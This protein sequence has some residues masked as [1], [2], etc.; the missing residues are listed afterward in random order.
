MHDTIAPI[1]RTMA[2]RPRSPRD[3]NGRDASPPNSV[4]CSVRSWCWRPCWRSARGLFSDVV[5]P[6]LVGDPVLGKRYLESFDESV[7]VPEADR[8]IRLR[9]NNVGFRGPDWPL[10]KPPG[11]RRIAVLGDSMIASV[12]V[13]EA[14]TLVGQLQ[15]LLDRSHPETKWE[16]MNFGVAGASPAQEMVLYREL[17]SRFDPDIVLCAFF[18]GNDLSDNSRRLSNNPRIYFDVDASGKL[19]Q[20][21]FSAERV[22]ASAW[23]NRYSRFYVWQKG[24]MRA[25]QN[26]VLE[27]LGEVS[28]GKWIFCSQPTGDVAHAW[29]VT[30]EVMLAF[31]REVESRGSLFAVVML[32]SACQIYR[33]LFASTRQA[34][35]EMA[36]YFE[37]GL[38]RPATGRRVP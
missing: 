15:Q 27:S 19:H 7:Y 36:P 12:A 9:F 31:Q 29:R 16:V 21:P 22:R 5:P 20:L 30:D 8:K 24:A 28:A 11:V 18:V 35:G 1:V 10:K 32:P 2:G 17:V 37:P 4:C 13:D 38:S 34:A 33:D 3:G 23:L 6:L 25:V 14:D 26:S